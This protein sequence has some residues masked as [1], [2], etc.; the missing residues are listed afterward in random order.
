ME[1]FLAV[2]RAELSGRQDLIERAL[3]AQDA[4]QAKYIL[5]ALHG[6]HQE[7]WDEQIEQLANEGLRAKFTQNADLQDFLCS[8][9][10]LILGEASTNTR[11]GIGMDL[12]N[13]EVLNPSKWSE[14]GK[15]LGR[16]LMK[17]R[18]ELHQKKNPTTD[19]APKQQKKGA[20]K[21]NNPRN[22]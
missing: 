8:T 9:R 18:Q 7:Q 1:H 6:D 15:L 17:L 12:Q 2:K 20:G 19:R 22:S 14:T 21:G 10:N 13:P 5:N 3:K 11:W 4:A 16:A